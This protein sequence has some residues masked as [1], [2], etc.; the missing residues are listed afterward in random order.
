MNMALFYRVNSHLAGRWL[1]LSALRKTAD[2]REGGARHHYRRSRSKVRKCCNRQILCTL[3]KHVCI[4]I[5][6]INSLK[7]CNAAVLVKMSSPI[8]MLSFKA[9][10]SWNPEAWKGRPVSRPSHM[11][12]KVICHSS[13]SD[14]HT[15]P[16]C[17]TWGGM[18]SEMVFLP[19]WCS[20]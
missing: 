20:G 10:N 9:V 4:Y 17:W 2:T 14:T 6:W 16:S 1:Q 8:K 15:P 19:V 18:T 7:A 3:E 11:N 5:I 12:V 13:S